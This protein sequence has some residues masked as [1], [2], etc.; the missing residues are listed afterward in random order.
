MLTGII[1][2]HG[3]RV[4]IKFDENASRIVAEKVSMRGLFPIP[5]NLKS[6]VLHIPET[7]RTHVRYIQGKMFKLHGVT[8]QSDG[9]RI[10]GKR[11]LPPF[12]SDYFQND[13][14]TKCGLFGAPLAA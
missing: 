8:S 2:N 9:R 7:H 12:F 5:N 6:E 13:R 4:R 1:R 10:P 14:G 11:F 3:G